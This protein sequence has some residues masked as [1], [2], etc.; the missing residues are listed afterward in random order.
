[1]T[2]EGKEAKILDV[3]AACLRLGKDQECE[4]ACDP[5]AFPMVAS[6]HAR[7][8][9]VPDGFAL[10]HLSRYNKTLLNDAE[11]KRSS[12]VK[13]GDRIRL[14][15]SGPAIE[16]VA[17]NALSE[18]EP[19]DFCSSSGTLQANS[20][21]LALL[22]GTVESKRFELGT[23]G[24]IG[25][26]ADAVPFLLNH[27]HVSRLHANLTVDKDGVVVA[28][29]GS[30][31]GTFVNGQRVK[32]PKKLSPGDRI[33]IGPFSLQFD[34]QGLVSRSRSNNIEL[35]A[36]GIQRLVSDRATRRPISLL[37]DVD[38]VIRPREFV[39]LLGPSG[40]GKSTLLAI[41]S[42]R[43]APN[44]GIVAV[45]GEDLHADFEALKEI[46]PSW[47]RRTSCTTP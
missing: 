8:E 25:R 9:Q 27:P 7:I 29:L 34:G 4:V 42:G 28:D 35:S 18:S 26:D 36:R 41:L 43:R 24:M 23:G 12:R 16:I 38:L 14:G 30:S 13:A 40:S 20:R 39:C 44:R 10:I 6:V 11:I 17:I 15:Y 5:A 33:D 3:A 37:E 46:S 21:N 1:M 19:I 2:S 31:N 22:R 32:R 47:P 45:N